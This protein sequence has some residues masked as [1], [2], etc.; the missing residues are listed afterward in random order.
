MP[1]KAIPIY[2]PFIDKIEEDLVTDCMKSTWI[3]SK[4]AYINKFEEQIKAYTNANYCTTTSSGT[5][6]LHLAML[7]LNIGKDDEVITTN[8]TY[9]ASTNAILF[10][11]AKPVFC[12]I[13]S[14]DLNIDVD[15]IESKITPKTKAILYTNVYGFLCNYDRLNKIAKKH[16][17]F[18]IE[19]AA[20]S[21]GAKYKNIMSGNLGDISTFS[22]FGNKTITTGEGGMVLCKNSQHYNKIIKLKN[23]GNSERT[24]FHDILGYNYRM[25]NIQAAIGIGQLNKVD[26]IIFLKKRLYNNYKTKLGSKVRFCKELKGTEPSYWM[27]PIIFDSQSQK[28]KIETKLRENSIE[29]RP[30]FT[31]IDQ[32]PFYEKS[33][34]KIANKIYKLGL[35]LPSYPSLLDEDQ[36][37][38]CKIINSTI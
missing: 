2:R 26:K 6:A 12:N 5:S 33:K 20:E 31:P 24:Y 11:G 1:K 34:C 23:Q 25:T 8:F 7:A 13:K 4:G 28:E 35:L 32:L 15:S 38:I 19:D 3:S 30:L 16:G 14:E 27:T 18:L 9:V 22:F 10:V 29:T 37:K 21:F 36:N 17:L